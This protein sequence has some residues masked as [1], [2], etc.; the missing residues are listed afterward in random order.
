[1]TRR[2]QPDLLYLVRHAD[3]IDMADDAARPLSPKGRA[4][5]A[6]LARFLAPSHAFQPTAIWHSPLV[7]ARETAELLQ[8]GLKLTAPLSEHRELVSEADPETVVHK[9]VGVRGCIAL[10]GHEP[11][12]SSLATL[13]V[14]GSAHRT[15]FIVQKAAIIALES[16]GRHWQVR[17]HISPEIVG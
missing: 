14:T 3:A 1:V 10:V 15:A 16:A 12:L 8:H 2:E 4:Q 17:W 6:A 7:R 13:L 5:M 9:L 11:H